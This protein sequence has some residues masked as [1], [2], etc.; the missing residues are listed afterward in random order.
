[1]VQIIIV[2]ILFYVGLMFLFSLFLQ[3]C[4]RNEKAFNERREAEKYAQSHN[5]IKAQE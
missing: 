5:S 1:M 4:T 3:G 2:S